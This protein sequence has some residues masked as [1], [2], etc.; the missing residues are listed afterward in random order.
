M[1]RSCGALISTRLEC[2][3]SLSGGLD[4][5]C[6]CEPQLAIGRQLQPEIPD[7][8]D[9]RRDGTNRILTISGLR[10]I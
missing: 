8:V 7:R 6:L 2:F 9:E 1:E 4:N 3:L 5:A 10:P